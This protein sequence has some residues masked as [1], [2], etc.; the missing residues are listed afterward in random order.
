MLV[1]ISP[2]LQATA[3][4]LDVSTGQPLRELALPG[5]PSSIAVAPAG[6]LLAFGLQDGRVLLTDAA[7]EASNDL[8]PCAAGKLPVAAVA[9]TAEGRQLMAAAG[10]VLAVWDA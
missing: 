3:L 2:C 5:C 4:L 8:G 9:F 1:F 10:S 6:Q 7:G